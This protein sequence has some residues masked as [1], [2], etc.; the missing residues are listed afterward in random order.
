MAK[1]RAKTKPA[2]RKSASNSSLPDSRGNGGELHQMAGE[3]VGT[4]TIQQGIPDAD[5]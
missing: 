3:D 2:A 1:A 5:A 4:F